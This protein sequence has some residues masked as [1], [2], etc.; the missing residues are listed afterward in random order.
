M[1]G[2]IGT[3]CRPGTDPSRWLPAGPF[4][5]KLG[6]ETD[7]LLV[8]G[9][10]EFCVYDI[11]S[12]AVADY[13]V[14]GTGNRFHKLRLAFR[15]RTGSEDVRGGACLLE[16]PH[17]SPNAVDCAISSVGIGVVVENSFGKRMAHRH[18]ARSL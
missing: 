3:G 11:L 9:G 4:R 18:E 6:G 5:K 14:S 8:V 16:V 7:V 10:R 15:Q 13:A 17:Q 1:A 2:G 12:V